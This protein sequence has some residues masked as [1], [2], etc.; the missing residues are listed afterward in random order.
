M[1]CSNEIAEICKIYYIL[2]ILLFSII[3]TVYHLF[4]ARLSRWRSL[5]GWQITSAGPCRRGHGAHRGADH[6]DV[7]EWR[8]GSFA[9]WNGWFGDVQHDPNKSQQ[10]MLKKTSHI[11]LKSLKF[12]ANKK[13][14]PFWGKKN[15]LSRWERPPLTSGKRSSRFLGARRSFWFKQGWKIKTDWRW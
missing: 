3:D 9:I 10:D 15:I 2:Y 12:L 6:R 4:P 5:G 11:W 7:S 13:N 8:E 1:T 14:G